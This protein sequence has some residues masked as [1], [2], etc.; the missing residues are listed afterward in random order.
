MIRGW[1][2]P[3][4]DIAEPYKALLCPEK[5]KVLKVYFLVECPDLVLRR[6]FEK[7]KKKEKAADFTD[8]CE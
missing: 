8:F 2:Y 1:I 3:T 5:L 7:E 4:C 6:K